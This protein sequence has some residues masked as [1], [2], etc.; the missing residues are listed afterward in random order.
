[1]D[2]LP[3]PPLPAQHM[4]PVCQTLI[5]LGAVTLCGL[6]VAHLMAPGVYV[7]FSGILLYIEREAQVPAGAG[8]VDLQE[9]AFAMLVEITERAMAHC[10]Q[11]QVGECA[12][13]LTVGHRC[14]I[15]LNQ[16]SIPPVD[17]CGGGR[18]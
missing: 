13:P 1:M 16:S 11:S 12:S 10:G 18:C 7:S 9:T 8:R 2:A 3:P 6:V 14:L 15:G 5:G 4:P 17:G